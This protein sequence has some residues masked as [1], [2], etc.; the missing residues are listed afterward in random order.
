MDGGEY[1]DLAEAT[2]CN[3]ADIVVDSENV[4]W[5]TEN[6]GIDEEWDFGKV[7]RTSKEPGPSVVLVRDQ[8]HPAGMAI[9]DTSVY[10][11]NRGE[12]LGSTG[13]VLKT[14]R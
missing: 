13:A 5:V 6:G 10:W 14:A 4:Y 2:G 7:F 11:V 1:T 3:P 8:L 9:D 12:L